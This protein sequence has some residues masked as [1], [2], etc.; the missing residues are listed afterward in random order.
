MLKKIYLA[1]LVA[2][3][4]M[5]AISTPD[6]LKTSER[7][8]VYDVPYN[9]TFKI[10]SKNVEAFIGNEVPVDIKKRTSVSSDVLFHS[11]DNTMMLIIRQKKS[12][13]QNYNNML[14]IVNEYALKN[15]PKANKKRMNEMF[16]LLA[17]EQRSVA[18]EDRVSNNDFT[19]AKNKQRANI[20]KD[21]E[22]YTSNAIDYNQLTFNEILDYFINNYYSINII[23]K[24]THDE[25]IR[26]QL[27]SQI[28]KHIADSQLV[29]PDLIEYEITLEELRQLK[30]VLVE[31]S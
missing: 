22:Q 20:I 6:E 18:L 28:K 17:L 4:S 31:N 9:K 5:Y 14:K 30:K 1:A 25:D 23:K 29:D 21:I 10:N 26:L 15:I 13:V 24:D 8:K 16:A 19:D 3:T 27:V 12:P 7:I 11:K 2:T